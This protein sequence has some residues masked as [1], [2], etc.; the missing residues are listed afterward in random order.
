MLI[1]DKIVFTFAVVSLSLMFL[2]P[3]Y[4]RVKENVIMNR[5]YKQ[6]IRE[7]ERVSK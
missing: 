7:L 1:A 3:L 6:R 5:E 2:I 4:K